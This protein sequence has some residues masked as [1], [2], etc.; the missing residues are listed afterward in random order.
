MG[1][2][3]NSELSNTIFGKQIELPNLHTVRAK[4]EED[5]Q[6]IDVLFNKADKRDAVRF[7]KRINA[8]KRQLQLEILQR[9][10]QIRPARWPILG[11]STAMDRYRGDLRTAHVANDQIF[12]HRFADFMSKD[13]ALQ[14]VQLHMSELSKVE[15]RRHCSNKATAIR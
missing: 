8:A 15:W 4:G 1:Y 3:K 7:C 9:Q 2:E 5:L 14:P 6:C 10:N 12:E 11:L 13:C